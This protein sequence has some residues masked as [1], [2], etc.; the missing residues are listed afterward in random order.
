MKYSSRIYLLVSL[1][2]NYNTR[3]DKE[4]QEYQISYILRGKMMELFKKK[5]KQQPHICEVVC[6]AEECNFICD[7]RAMNRHVAWKHPEL[8]QAT[9]KVK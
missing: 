2:L 3:T 9:T 6:P 1:F 4:Y 8:T 7:S 5:K